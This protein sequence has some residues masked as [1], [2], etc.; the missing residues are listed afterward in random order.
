[1][2]GVATIKIEVVDSPA[3]HTTTVAAVCA[4]TGED[5]FLLKSVL[6]ELGIVHDTFPKVIKKK[7]NISSISEESCACT[8]RT[9]TPAPPSKPPV[10]LTEVNREQLQSFLLEY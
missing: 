6:M 2:L 5:M 8:V 9:A 1:M 3:H 7:V 4:G 10:P